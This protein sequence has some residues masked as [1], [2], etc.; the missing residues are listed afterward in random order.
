VSKAFEKVCRFIKRHSMFDPARVVVVAVSGGP[1]SVA[2]LDMMMRLASTAP[3]PVHI[4][5]LNH[6]LRAEDSD[7]D[8]E[9]VRALAERL[10]LPATIGSIDVRREARDTARGIEEVA[11]ELRYKFLLATAQEAGADL[12]ATGHTM[13]DQAETFLM[14]LA[15]GAGG[16]GLASMRPVTK[17]HAF[18]RDEQETEDNPFHPSLIRPLLAITREEVEEYCSERGLVFRT[19][20]S[21]ASLDY[22][23]N[24]VRHDVIAALKHVNPRVVEHI[25]SAASLIAS[26]QD[27]LDALACS[28]LDQAQQQAARTGSAYKAVAYKAVAYKAAAF[29]SQPT[30][31]RRRMI[32]EA[33][34]R[35]AEVIR[36]EIGAKHVMAVEGLLDERMSGA[37][38]NLPEGLE[39]WRD[40]D[41]LVFKTC[42]NS[43]E[44]GA[45]RRFNA[46][47]SRLEA[48]GFAVSIDRG[49]PGHLL[50]GIISEA[51]REAARSGQDWFMAVLDDHALPEML[52]LRTRAR[53]ERALVCG[54]QKIKKL[55]NLMI[56]HRIPSS[57]RANW[58]IVA[59]PDGRYIW[60]PG[61]PPAVEFAARDETQALAILRA[62]G[63]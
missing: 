29:V 43:E 32:I 22:A 28:L 30:A 17:A 47:C 16:R 38:V 54:Q 23:R 24:R 1:D 7:T 18:G 8:A 2:L 26:D 19:D 37:R 53:G 27:A 33:T 48:G 14:R 57:R 15:R 44:V 41:L 34:R 10:N 49:L 55:K 3:C 60:S 31:L 6:L 21:N 39:V 52:V 4:A 13:N 45:E 25:S 11:R 36:A 35:L 9:F 63:V 20:A 58:P 46:D 62:S 42:A 12:I 56:D 50:G 5:H 51:R 40:Y 59:T 61:L